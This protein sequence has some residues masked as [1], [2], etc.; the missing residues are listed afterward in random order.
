LPNPAEY[1]ADR[2][3]DRDF[4]NDHHYQSHGVFLSG[5]RPLGCPNKGYRTVFY[6]PTLVNRARD[7]RHGPSV[8]RCSLSRPL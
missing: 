2:H 5:P 1:E 7:R 8:F 6:A 3:R 4:K